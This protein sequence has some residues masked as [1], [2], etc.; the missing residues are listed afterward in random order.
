MYLIM[1]L[2]VT[3]MTW[4]DPLVYIGQRWIQ[5]YTQTVTVT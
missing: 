2:V 5:R 1:T 3:G 4:L